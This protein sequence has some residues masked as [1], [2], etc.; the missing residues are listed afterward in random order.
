MIVASDRGSMK[1]IRIGLESNCRQSKPYSADLL[2]PAA[3][4]K[5]QRLLQCQ[6][7]ISAAPPQEA[8]HAS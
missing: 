2:Q 6:R 8:L 3:L 7:E 1:S 5:L 4:G